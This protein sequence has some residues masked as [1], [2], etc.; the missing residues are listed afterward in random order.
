M[1]LCELHFGSV[2]PVLKRILIAGSTILIISWSDKEK[3]AKKGK[4]RHTAPSERL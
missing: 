4:G 2:F 1:S 3:Q